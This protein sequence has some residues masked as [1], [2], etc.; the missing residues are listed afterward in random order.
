[1]WI[2]IRK[3]ELENNKFSMGMP[4][5]RFIR[6]FYCDKQIRRAEL[7]ISALGIFRVEI[8]GKEIDEY[9]MPGY[10][11][12]NKYVPLCSYDITYVLAKENRIAVTV[13]DGWFVGR[14]GYIAKRGI[15]GDKT[16]LYATIYLTYE[17]GSEEVIKTDE[18]WKAYDS[19]IEYADFF[20]GECVNENK[21]RDGFAEYDAL[22]SAQVVKEER[23]FKPYDMEPVVCVEKLFPKQTRK[24]NSILLDFGQNFAGVV[25]FSAKGKKGL[26]ITVRHAEMLSPDGELYMENLRSAHCTDILILSSEPCC[27]APKFTYHG[28]RY[29]EISVSNGSLED[30]DI[31]DIVGLVL[32]QN[33]KRTG[34]FDCSDA[35]VNKV[36]Q[37]A[38]WGQLGNFISVPT[39]CPQ[40][41]ERLG[42]TGD[43]QVFCDSAMYNADCNRFYRNYMDIMRADCCE[44][45]AVPSF[46]PMF[47]GVNRETC[48]SPCWGDAVAVIPYMHYRF[49]G[50]KRIIKENLSQAKKWIDFYRAHLDENNLV[51]GLFTYGDWLSVKEETDKAVMMQ[52]FYGY[53]L[54]LVA[55][56]CEI[57]GED[58]S[59]YKE[60]HGAAKV[61]FRTYLT[62]EKEC[63][64]SDTQTAYLVAYVAE[65][66]SGEEIREPLLRAI[67]RQD[68][69]LT[70]GFIGVRFLLPVLSD[71]G[72]T[73][74]AY[75]LMKNTQYP[76]W[77]YSVANG[78]TTIWE[79][80]NGYTADKGFFNPS[81]N[82]FNHY[83]L[84]SCVYWLYAYVLGI[85]PQEGKKIKIAPVFSKQLTYAKGSY[86]FEKGEVS[87]SWHYGQEHILLEVEKQG[88]F[89][90]EFF[91]RDRIILSQEKQ[92]NKYLV[93]LS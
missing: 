27:F 5:T 65:F 30:V 10:T 45:G 43:T 80:W 50:D 37:N 14:L 26:K 33:L 76:S 84:G 7:K 63:V 72:E 18:N 77:G 71:I 75:K 59:K 6:R 61:A 56:M 48:G 16:R 74:L 31:T 49:Y 78:A 3:S 8:N 21:R 38:Y 88:D 79:R 81:M 32:S 67:H 82:S 57:M 11:N 36:Y 47:F 9:F 62:N 29:A 41:D 86:A 4:L 87:V 64:T 34:Y 13:G 68:D 35:I 1:M 69:T 66:M 51:Q 28:F 53:S 85:Q 54:L 58:A 46:V 55:K 92:G 2:T 91:F 83:S 24:R 23:A 73:E 40:R 52:C 25:N 42:W 20:D 12:Y 89:E 60:W 17:D 22:N 90:I 70:T 15:F 44:D 93:T 39:D 19:E